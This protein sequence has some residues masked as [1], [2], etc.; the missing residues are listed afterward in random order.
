MEVPDDDPVVGREAI[1]EAWR[2]RFEEVG[3]TGIKVTVNG[4]EPHAES[5][6]YSGTGTFRITVQPKENV[7]V[8]RDGAFQM[9][10]VL[11]DGI[12]L[13][14]REVLAYVVDT[15]AAGASEGEK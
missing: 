10:W 14:V 2:H 1:I 7:I 13:I 8:E 4:V 11:K 15:N 12:T 6:G 3:V 9:F 5:G